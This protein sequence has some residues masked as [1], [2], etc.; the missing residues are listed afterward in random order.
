M[1]GR[2]NVFECL[3]HSED[4][5]TASYKVCTLV[6]PSIADLFVLPL[7]I[8]Y[9]TGICIFLGWVVQVIGD[10]NRGKNVFKIHVVIFKYIQFYLGHIFSATIKTWN[11]SRGFMVFFTVT[12][13]CPLAYFTDEN[14]LQFAYLFMSPS[15]LCSA[16]PH[17]WVCL[18]LSQLTVGKWWRRREAR[19]WTGC[20]PIAGYLFN[21]FNSYSVLNNS[22]VPCNY[23]PSPPLR[24]Y[25]LGEAGWMGEWINACMHACM[26]QWIHN[27]ASTKMSFSPDPLSS[28][29]LMSG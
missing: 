27:L 2:L 18:S 6:I 26:N 5:H 10:I 16:N 8:I 19:S 7:F 12:E 4:S 29:P 22:W 17:L 28:D 20:Q 9:N 14:V 23:L 3:V 21:L 11:L 1:R 13:L 24:Q 15:I 25:H